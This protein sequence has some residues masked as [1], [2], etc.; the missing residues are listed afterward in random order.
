MKEMMPGEEKRQ[1]TV[2]AVTRMRLLDDM[3]GGVKTEG[4][5][6]VL[7]LDSF[8][9]QIMSNICGV[10][11]LLDFGVSLVENIK[12]P[13]KS[14][15]QGS[16]IYFIVPEDENIALLTSDFSK[17]SK[18]C[19]KKA[20]VFFTS[21]PGGHH[22][23]QIRACSGLLERLQT[24][25]EVNV[26]YML[27]PDNRSFITGQ[28]DALMTFFGPAAELRSAYSSQACRI[29]EQLASV[30]ATMKELPAIR[31]RAPLPPGEDYPDGLDSRL[32]TCQQVAIELSRQLAIYQDTDVVPERETCDLIILD[33]GY[34]PL[35]PIIHE[36][37]YESMIHDVL[38]GDGSLNGR[39][40]HCEVVSQSGQTEEKDH[41]LDEK[42]ELFVDL[43]HRHFAEVSTKISSLLEDLVKNSRPRG[44]QKSLNELDLRSMAKLVQSLPKYQ[45]D[46]RSLSIH[47]EIASQL[48]KIIEKSRLTDIGS[49]EQDI[50]YG[51][52]TSK[53]LISFLSGNQ[54]LETTGKLRLLLCYATTHLEKLDTVRLNQWKKL[55]RLDD[56]GMKAITNLEYLGIPVCK[57]Q[58]S[59]LSGISFGRRKRKMIRKDRNI[60]CINNQS[61][62]LSRFLPLLAELVE[63]CISGRLSSEDFPFIKPPSSP[64]VDSYSSGQKSREDLSKIKRKSV[65]SFRTIRPTGT[66]ASKATT[67]SNNDSRSDGIS[68]QEEAH[69]MPR[70]RIFLFIIGGFTYSE[71]RVV[72]QLS[73][74]LNSDIFLGGTSVVTPGSFIQM[75]SNLA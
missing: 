13:Q 31:Y 11:D 58:R 9:T 21:A 48:N 46:L 23:E 19:F 60:A 74:A 70:G 37:T 27:Y 18:A 64:S 72:H 44:S 66:W 50:V 29:A 75:L 55:A 67:V 52:A 6:S 20:H 7:V 41:V 43:R 39:V 12:V 73:S 59:H 62:T 24:L 65:S 25:K 22:I 33:R 17:K 63:D 68:K 40:F 28:K 34:D 57:R 38:E 2:S 51:E 69:S 35:A 56:I 26:E 45:D 53:E 71:L 16:A 32:L 8:T 36:W 5:W 42:D 47:V 61:F 54:L 49:L 14:L 30:F 3:L 1:T 15:Q 10:S 4:E